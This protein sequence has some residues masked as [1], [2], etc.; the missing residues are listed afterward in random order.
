MITIP[1]SPGEL[2]TIGVSVLL[3]GLSLALT[4][5][6]FWN[7]QWHRYKSFVI[8]TVLMLAPIF[9]T[10]VWHGDVF[11]S[12]FLLLSVVVSGLSSWAIDL[13]R[14]RSEGEDEETVRGLPD[15]G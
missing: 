7:K 3:S 11:L 2:I 1:L 12:V 15:H 6:L 10:M 4:H 13:V 8:G 14:R 5:L 9:I